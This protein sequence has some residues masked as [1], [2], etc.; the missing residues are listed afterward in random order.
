MVPA[1]VQA[2]AVEQG[3]LARPDPSGAPTICARHQNRLGQSRH[4]G[5][6]APCSSCPSRNDMAHRVVSPAQAV[7]RNPQGSCMTAW[8]RPATVM[9]CVLRQHLPIRGILDFDISG[10]T[11]NECDLSCDPIHYRLMTAGH[12]MH[13]IILRR[14]A[15]AM[16]RPIVG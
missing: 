5:M 7:R 13:D 11:V 8:S 14:Q 3:A 1:W 6:P 15:D 12:I 4:A 2:G 16:Y 9:G 10:L